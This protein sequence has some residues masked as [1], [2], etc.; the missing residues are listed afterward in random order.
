M[1]FCNDWIDSCNMKKKLNM[2]AIS[3]YLIRL[4]KIKRRLLFEKKKFFVD[5]LQKYLEIKV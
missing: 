5:K 3:I 2:K 4:R 1:I